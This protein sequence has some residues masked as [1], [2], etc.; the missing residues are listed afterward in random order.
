MSKKDKAGV[1][2]SIPLTLAEKN[3]ALYEAAEAKLKATG[4]DTSRFKGQKILPADERDTEANLYVHLVLMEAF[5]PTP[6]RRKD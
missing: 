1:S 2:V 6:D 5:T 4:I 3:R